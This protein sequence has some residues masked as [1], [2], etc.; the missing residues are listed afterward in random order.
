MA[1]K[2]SHILQ[3][4]DDSKTTST[5]RILVVISPI[6]SSRTEALGNKSNKDSPLLFFPRRPL[7]CF[8]ITGGN[9]NPHE[10]QQAGQPGKD[11]AKLTAQTCRQLQQQSDKIWRVCE[12]TH[13]LM[14]TSVISISTV[15][16]PRLCFRAVDPLCS[17]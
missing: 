13:P 10:R 2:L 5:Q 7:G 11:G 12:L 1:R 4:L 3:F 8:N 16:L 6:L 15:S 14:T 9:K 17:K